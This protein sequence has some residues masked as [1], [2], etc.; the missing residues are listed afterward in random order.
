MSN[1]KSGVAILSLILCTL[2][3]G[4]VFAALAVATNNS[5]IF[6]AKLAVEKQNGVIEN[7]AYI[8]VYT[9]EEIKAVARQAYANNYLALYEEQVDMSGFI[10]LVLNEMNN[11]VPREQLSKYNVFVSQDGIE[12][13]AK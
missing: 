5:A 6:K 1:G 4:L 13:Q 11:T 12:V 7:S 9:L 8:K 2:V 3:V 10:T